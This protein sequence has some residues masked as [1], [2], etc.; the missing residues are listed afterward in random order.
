MY[1]IRYNPA[2]KAGETIYSFTPD[3]IDPTSMVSLGNKRF[4]IGTTAGIYLVDPVKK[5][6]ISTGL[7]GE[8]ISYLLHD[9]HGRL[10]AAC[11]SKQI[12]VA[13]PQE[14]GRFTLFTPVCKDGVIR[15]E[16]Y[17]MEED[18]KGSFWVGTLSG[19]YRLS[20]EEGSRE[21]VL[22]EYLLK[23][24]SIFDLH[25]DR[26]GSLWI[27]SYYGDVRYFNPAIDNYDYYPTQENDVNSM[28]GVVL[29]QIVE[30][31]ANTLYIATEGSGINILRKGNKQVGHIVSAPG[32][33]PHDKIR[34][35]WYDKEY[36]RLYMSV[37]MK[38]LYC[39][40]GSTKRIYP[41]IDRVMTDTYQRII[42]EIIPYKGDLILLTQNGLFKMNR[43]TQGISFFFESEELRE[44]T[45]GIVRTVFVDERDVMWVSSHLKGLFTIN[46]RT[47]QVSAFYGDGLS[48]NSIIPSAILQIGGSA[49]KGLYFMTLRSG[50]LRYHADKN[51]FSLINRENG[52]LLSDICY[53]MTFTLYGSLVV[54]SNRGLTILNVSPD[55]KLLSP[56]HLPFGKALPLTGFS[57]DCGLYASPHEDRIYVGGLYGLFSFSERDMINSNMDYPMFFSSLSVNNKPVK[58]STPLLPKSILATKKIVLPYSKNS[59]S[60]TFASTNY[61][62]SSFTTYEYKL[63]GLDKLWTPAE[64]NTIV[65]NSLRPGIYH[66][67]VREEADPARRIQLEIVVKSPYWLSLPAIALYSFLIFALI[68]WIV[69]FYRSRSRLKISLALEKKELE[70]IETVNKHKIEFFTNISNEFRTPLT[71]IVASLDRLMHDTSQIGKG[72]IERIRRQVVRLQE[73]MTELLDFRKMESG[74]LRLKVRTANISQ[75]VQEIL[76]SFSEYTAEKKVNCRFLGA[77]DGLYIWFDPA[78]MQKVFYNLLST[79]FKATP[80]KGEVVMS[81]QRKNNKMEIRIG[82]QLSDYDLSGVEQFIEDFN[83]PEESKKEGI[84][85]FSDR[86]IGLAFS[87]GIIQLHKGSI[88]AEKEED[89]LVFVIS[90]RL[91][92]SHFDQDELEEFPEPVAPLELMERLVVDRDAEELTEEW[93]GESKGNKLFKMLLVDNDDEILLLLKDS[94]SLIY[95]VNIIKDGE[96]AYQYAISEQPDIILSEINIPRL[97]GLEMCEMLKTNVKT[98]HIPV[99]LLAAQPSFEQKVD[100][101]RRGADEYIEKPFDME[102]LF[103][104]CNK[105][106]RN[107][108]RLLNL[109]KSIENEP[110]IRG[111]NPKDRLFLEAA[112][113]VILQHLSDPNFDVNLWS[114][115]LKIGRTH[116]FNQV[117][118]ITGLT[119]N[120]YVLRLKMNKA[121]LLLDE[122]KVQNPIAQIA[123]QL[124]FTNPAYFSRIFKKQFGVTPR[125]FR[126]RKEGGS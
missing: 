28:H 85:L 111:T 29:G 92:N 104:Q 82:Y 68:Y 14:M 5:K 73:L 57:G 119:P 122:E 54:T 108:K 12:Y 67:I 79:A 55:G 109:E 87:R 21:A 70:R 24:S 16:I 102:L 36:D 88:R 100:S 56:R 35:L 6:T 121:M 66:L 77:N 65:Y 60:L 23:G 50:L 13:K 83:H 46:L 19:L 53:C 91:G 69:R 45:S 30:D 8:F 33:L 44:M 43:K 72:R 106:V 11:R 120:D 31:R 32:G 71:L 123:Y 62:S 42:E 38:G 113:R 58:A 99:V 63:E 47:N 94:L 78:Q 59:I 80:P 9:S 117:K 86:G 112:D 126:D 118:R 22:D 61:L 75:F 26:Q 103:L 3:A 37:Y 10:W 96:Q 64:H 4:G 52:L 81:V 90:L 97:S 105:L 101:I 18:A 93:G 116:L 34:A 74:S 17:C 48:E 125:E 40:D 41:V 115:E 51:S 76:G 98:L 49:E 7:H 20:L 27:G 89:K 15:D 39:R 1:Y 124:G 25:S 84:T 110:L 95:E 114:C 107:S 2:K